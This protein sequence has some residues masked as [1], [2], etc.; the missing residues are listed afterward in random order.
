ME[1]E[2]SNTKFK[3]ISGIFMPLL[4]LLLFV[5]FQIVY[6]MNIAN[7][8][9]ESLQNGILKF[10]I[11]AIAIIAGFLAQ[12]IAGVILLVYELKMAAQTVTTLDDDLIPLMQRCA[13]IAIWVVVFIT[14]LP[15][16]GVNI[17]AL[18]TAIGVGSLAIAL[19]AKDTISNIIAG[20]L[21]MIDRPFRSGDKI[22]IPSGEVVSVLNIGTRRSSFLTDEKT[23]VIVP[24]IDLSKSKIINYTYGKEYK[25]KEYEQKEV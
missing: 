12:K 24:N 16:Y 20:F 13:N 10:L 25:Q 9:P 3:A 17:N 19:S 21:I 2:K 18:I 4:L 6:S 15:V 14:V 23:V 22:K 11:T 8:L 1:K 5:A 7:L